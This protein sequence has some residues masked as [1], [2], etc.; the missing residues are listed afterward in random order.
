MTSVISF[1]AQKEEFRVGSED[2]VENL[3]IGCDITKNN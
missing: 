2:Y 3:Q 1:Y